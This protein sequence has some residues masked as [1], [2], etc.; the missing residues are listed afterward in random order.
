[1]ICVPWKS[2][3]QPSR[4]FTFHR[5][6]CPA[7]LLYELNKSRT[8][9]LYLHFNI[10]Y[11]RQDTAQSLLLYSDVDNQRFVL[12]L[13]IVWPIFILTYTSKVWVDETFLI[14]WEM[15][16][17]SKQ[18]SALLSFS[19]FISTFLPSVYSED[20]RLTE[21]FPVSPFLPPHIPPP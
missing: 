19:S 3:P 15:H 13:Q 10:K 11:W 6:S 17:V 4:Y 9:K 5:N 1:M 16:T 12:N 20:L 8:R 18:L 2:K 7:N 21:N 14:L